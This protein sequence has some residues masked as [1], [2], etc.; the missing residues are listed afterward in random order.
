MALVALLFIAAQPAGAKDGFH[1][2][3]NMLFN[4]ISG[5]I[6]EPEG[7]ESGHGLGLH[8]GYGFNQDLA[9]EAG[10]WKTKHSNKDA[11]KAADLKAVTIDLKVNFPLVD[12][13]IEPYLLFGGGIFTVEQNGMSREGKGGRVGI[14]MDIYLFPDTSLNMGFTRS[15]VT[16][17]NN[18][19]DIDCRIDTMDVGLTYHF[20]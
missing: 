5:D 2:G 3:I 12:S 10:I 18:T 7:I 1:I 9:V 19:A 6:N 11:G 13:Y 4:D 20:I 17:T 8:G 16:F 15:N 14:G